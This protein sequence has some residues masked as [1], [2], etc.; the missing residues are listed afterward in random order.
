MLDRATPSA[1]MPGRLPG[2]R[3]RAIAP[4]VRLAQ[5]V[6]IIRLAPRLPP[7]MPPL[8]RPS[9]LPP[10]PAAAADEDS[11]QEA[12]E[13]HEAH[14]A[15]RARDEQL[16]AWLAAAAAGDAAAFEAFYAATFT[17]ARTVARR[18]LREPA[19]VEDLLADCY[20][21]AWRQVA[22]FDPARG[23]AMTWLLV[24]VRSRGLDTLRAAAA[25][26]VQAAGAFA[27]FATHGPHALQGAAA[28][29]SADDAFAGG[30][31]GE[32]TLA[33]DPADDPA[34]QLWRREAGAGLQA[35]LA[36]L[37]AAERWVLGLAYLRELSHAEI[38][39]C[40]GM[41]LG[42]VKSHAQR[43]QQKLRARL[44]PAGAPPVIP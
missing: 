32:P 2:G 9:S 17:Q 34:E 26:P 27:A 41:P 6:R 38:A 7:A 4:P 43:A 37:S 14:Q 12:Q 3:P 22:R 24:R 21:E 1:E 8:A 44:L 13:A 42:T 16:A 11:A 25:R 28:G 18:L 33:T 10:T 29:R 35:A 23:S 30:P 5:A 19:A 39:A 20:F 40:T 36:T 31:G 15:R